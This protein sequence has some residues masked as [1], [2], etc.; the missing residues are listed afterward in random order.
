MKNLALKL[1][2]K[3]LRVLG[4]EK[5]LEIAYNL[6]GKE[7]N[8]TDLRKIVNLSQSSLSQHL[9]ILRKEKVVKTRRVA[10]TIFYSLQSESA[11]KLLLFI[12]KMYNK[13]YKQ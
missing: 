10:Q 3:L 11:V 4:N 6:M 2:T 13:V 12:D 1:G 7:L 8:V 5:R 9:A